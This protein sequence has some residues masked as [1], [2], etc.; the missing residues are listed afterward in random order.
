MGC[1]GHSWEQ[2]E[3]QQQRAVV[4]EAGP[5]TTTNVIPSATALPSRVGLFAFA[6]G[7]DP[8]RL[9]RAHVPWLK[10]QQ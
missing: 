2:Y 4:P 6:L 1:C 7:L 3:T 8:C 5:T 9:L 10:T